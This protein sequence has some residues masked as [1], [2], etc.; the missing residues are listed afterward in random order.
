MGDNLQTGLVNNGYIR[1]NMELF[2]AGMLMAGH[3]PVVWMLLVTFTGFPLR[4]L[5]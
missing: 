3:N 2:A 4:C 5:P 1:L